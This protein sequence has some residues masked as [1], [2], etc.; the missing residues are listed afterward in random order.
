MT[1]KSIKLKSLIFYIVATFAFGL[2]GTLLGGNTSEVYKTFERPPLSPPG[3]VFPIVWSILYLLLGVGAYILST[4]KRVEVNKA[5]NIYW[6][7][8]LFNAIWPLIFWR[9]KAFYLAASIIVIMIIL[10]VILIVRSVKI[11]KTAV[12]LFLPYT[13][14][15]LFALYLNLG[16]AILN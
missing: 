16:I 6:L 13:I 11:N 5:L 15:L 7:Q 1:V 9:F 4:S 8:L 3:I 2:L 12:Y 10:T 14:W